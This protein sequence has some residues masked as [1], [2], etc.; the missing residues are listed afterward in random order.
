MY[1]KKLLSIVAA[2]VLSLFIVCFGAC[3]TSNGQ[4][5]SEEPKLY[6]LNELSLSL[7]VDETFQ[8]ELLGIDENEEVKWTTDNSSVAK[9]ANGAVTGV[10]PG[11]A[12]IRASID[13]KS[14]TC[15]V[16]VSFAYDNA[17]YLTLEN[18]IAVNGS[19][20]LT[21]LKG[22]KY[23]LSPALIDGEKVK[24]MSFLLD[25]ENAAL[26]ISGKEIQGV[27]VVENAKLIVSCN[28]EQQ[29]YKINVFVTVKEG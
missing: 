21:L 9:V 28:Y 2:L 15:Q 10:G 8:L 4:Q 13:G 6:A 23:F 29:E 1:K 16:T 12:N 5:S 11:K 26:Q 14:F 18:E 3:K 27:S 7:D 20:Y 22:E 19:Y 17:V 25:S 24:G